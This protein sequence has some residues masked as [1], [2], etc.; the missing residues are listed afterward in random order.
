MKASSLSNILIAAVFA[1]V[2]VAGQVLGSIRMDGSEFQ[3]SSLV[4]KPSASN[5]RVSSA[6]SSTVAPAR[7]VAT[8]GQPLM[9]VGSM[10]PQT[11]NGVV[12]KF[13]I[14]YEYNVWKTAYECACPC[15]A[16]PVCDGFWDVVD[17]IRVVNSAYRGQAEAKT[18]GCPLAD[19]DVNC[20][21]YSNTIDVVLIIEVV[22]RAVA[23][24]DVF[25]SPC[26]KF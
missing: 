14:G 26:K 24:S 7:I 1:T 22:F 13:G 17:I 5:K 16:D 20:D 9:G 11:A 21:G 4:A 10:T 3:G 12:Y 15:A 2:L 8:F 25:C 6:N 23:P 19:S 18:A